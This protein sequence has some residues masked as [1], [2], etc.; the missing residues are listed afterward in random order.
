M[1]KV[2]L[3]IAQ[4][5]NQLVIT[6]GYTHR[7]GISRCVQGY[8]EVLEMHRAYGIPMS[9]HLSG[10]LLEAMLWHRPGHVDEMRELVGG[11]GMGL[12]GGTYSEPIM[13]TLTP[14][15]NRL[16]LATMRDLLAEHFPQDAERVET[17]WLPER[18]WDPQL[19]GV[20]TDPSLPGG[21]YRRVL[22]DDRLLAAGRPSRP[23]GPFQW[24]DRRRPPSYHPGLVD[25]DSLRP[26][27][28]IVGGQ[29]LTMVPICSYL[30]YLFPPRTA[31][32]WNFLER[33]LADLSARAE[34]GEQ[35][36][37]VYADDMERSAGV[38]G[39]EPAI[40]E[41]EHLLQWL[42]T[43][44][45]VEVVEL[46]SWL[47]RHRFPERG[48]V[49][50]GS[51]YELEL[52]WGASADF[53][54]WSQDPQWSPYAELLGSVQTMIA[55]AEDQLS[56]HRGAGELLTLAWRV[57]MI[58]QHE[59]AWRDP[60]FG[61]LD[62]SQRHLAPWVRATAAHAALA[63]PLVKA[64]YWAADGG[65]TARAEQ[66]DIDE[67]GET[68]LIL[69][70]RRMW[71][72]I[73]PQRGARLTLMCHR[74]NTGCAVIVG[75]PADDWNYQEELH[76]FMDQPAAHPGAL[77]HRDDPHE[78][79][80]VLR[81][82]TRHG[83]AVDL[84]RKGDT[85]WGRRYA[86]VDGIPGLVVCLRDVEP[87]SVLDNFLTPDYLHALT[88]GDRGQPLTGRQLAGR[89]HGQ[90]WSWLG[91]DPA[92]ATATPDD[93]A[94]GHGHLLGVRTAGTSAELI[95][96]AGVVSDQQIDTWLTRARTILGICPPDPASG[97]AAAEPG[98]LAG[99]PR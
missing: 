26:R 24:A 13:P 66:T 77:S 42:A 94:A 33:M 91:F 62:G 72:V 45:S 9:L 81:T 89:R 12:L 37:L 18:V 54:G 95:I 56:W 74:D 35:I 27:V 71:C 73:S 69:A 85:A 80:S 20:F 93:S 68:E 97:S 10:T 21:P 36:L 29:R 41:Y 83:V 5:A 55:T 79:W 90:R 15:M 78:Q 50:A 86:L 43:S 2:A 59:T 64:A 99:D 96:G 4:H 22:V 61:C 30:R 48:A 51:Y 8:L 70:D 57:L 32:Q 14:P 31:P 23:H 60:V 38:G 34:A 53:T 28:S 92:Q 87:G 3:S 11:A 1:T 19:H 17:A 67:D 49:P 46:D 52:E 25:T 44:E 39:W 88:H 75:N 82:H 76:R 6:D 47:D 58:G 7:D 16:Q 98:A 63:R 65:C 40:K 84:Y